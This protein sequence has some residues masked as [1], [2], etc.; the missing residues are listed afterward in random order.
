MDATVTDAGSIAAD[1]CGWQL[2]ADSTYNPLNLGDQYKVNGLK[3]KVTFHKPGTR[4]FC[5]II[6]FNTLQKGPG[7]EAD[8]V[9]D[10]ISP[11]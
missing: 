10:R 7:G 2:V 9:I 3:V 4:F 1:G 5:G 6:L 8:I 11:Q